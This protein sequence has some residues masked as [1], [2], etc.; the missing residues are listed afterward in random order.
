MS[1]GVYGGGRCG[2]SGE[3][4]FLACGVCNRRPQPSPSRRPFR[5]PLRTASPPYPRPALCPPPG[6]TH[7][8]ASATGRGRRPLRPLPASGRRGR[9]LGL[10]AVGAG[11]NAPL[12]PGPESCGW[13]DWPQGH[14]LPS[15]LCR[16]VRAHLKLG[17]PSSS[18]AWLE[19]FRERLGGGT[20]SARV[21]LIGGVG[22]ATPGHSLLLHPRSRSLTPFN[23][24]SLFV[25]CGCSGLIR[26]RLCTGII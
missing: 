10:R 8:S 9:L 13:S 17:G 1:G 7:G 6:P 2:R 14:Y 15:R 11:R 18:S 22:V 23:N 3:R 5:S 20:A 12:G 19:G 26:G 21:E 16:G 4:A 24:F 25:D